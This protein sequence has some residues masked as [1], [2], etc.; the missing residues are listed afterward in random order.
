MIAATPASSKRLRD[1][2]RGQAPTSPPSLRP[3]PCRR[4]HRAR[5]RRGRESARGLLHQRRIAHRGGADD[6][7]G[8]ALAEPAIDG[9]AVA[10]AAAELHR[11]FHRGEDALD[12]RGIHRLAGKGAVEID[13]MQI[14]EALRCERLR[15][16]RRIAVEH[17]R[18]RHVALL[19]AH[20]MAVLQIDGGKQDHGTFHFRESSRSARGRASGS[21]PD[22]IAC[23]PCCRAPTI[24]VTA[25]P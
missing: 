22:G 4:A 9:G 3:R 6:D 14:F 1:I 10:D 19:Q 8:D 20:G 5:R 23:R 15:L 13:D 11:N 2:E 7:A 24:A 16:R 18:A 25:P 21:S 17:G 12:R